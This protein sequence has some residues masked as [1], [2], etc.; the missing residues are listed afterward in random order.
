M[1]LLMSYNLDLNGAALALFYLARILLKNG[2]SVIFAS[3]SDGALRQ[4]LYQENIP[5]IIDPNLQM[6]TLREVRWVH[7]FHKIICNTLH[8]YQFLSD[9]DM[10]DK[11][12]WWLHDPPM[13][14]KSLNK[15]LLYKIKGEGLTVCAVSPLAEAAFKEYF[16]DFAV[17]NLLYGIRTFRQVK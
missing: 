13:F 4:H 9:R 15:E 11:V 16:P 2:I 7:G 6:R 12:I 8:Y 5:V 10:K 3:W 1:I 17:K 14:Y